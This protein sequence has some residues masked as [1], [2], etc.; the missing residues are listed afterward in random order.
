MAFLYLIILIHYIQH[1]IVMLM[2]RKEFSQEILVGV[3]DRCS[4]CI[5]LNVG[6]YII[7][8]VRLRKPA[9]TARGFHANHTIPPFW[10]N[11]RSSLQKHVDVGKQ[12]VGDLV[13]SW[14]VASH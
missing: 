12:P 2:N 11:D 14:A 6:S 9:V 10:L 7:A 13:P 3:W 1:G 8:K 4:Y 5:V